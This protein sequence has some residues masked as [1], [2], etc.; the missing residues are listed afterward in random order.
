MVGTV[1]DHGPNAGSM[2]GDYDRQSKTIC[3]STKAKDPNGNAIVQKT[4]V[5][6]KSVDERVLVLSAPSEQK[7]K[8]MQIRFIRRK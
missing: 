2:T 1:I 7:D 8:F 3:W 4:L 6:H 5:T